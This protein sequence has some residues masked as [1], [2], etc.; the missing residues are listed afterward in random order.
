MVDER[1]G[2][3][4]WGPDGN[5]VEQFAADRSAQAGYYGAGDAVAAVANP[6]ANFFGVKKADCGC[7]GKQQQL[8]QMFPA[9]RRR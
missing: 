1:T 9:V 3:E 5:A 6:I 7:A 2:E 4:F 8:N